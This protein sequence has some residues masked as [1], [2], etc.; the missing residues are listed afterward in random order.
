MYAYYITLSSAVLSDALESVVNVVAGLIGLYSLKLAAKPKDSNHPYGHGKIEFITSG[1]EGTLIVVSSVVILI[2]IIKGL[3]NNSPVLQIYDGIILILISAILN[4]VVGIK[5]YKIGMKNKSIVLESEGKHL[6]IDA[7]SSIIILI[8]LW[9]IH[10]TNLVIIDRIIAF[11][12]AI[13]IFYNGWKILRKSY[14]G[15]MDEIDETLLKEFI[16]EINK[17]RKIEWIDLHNL[18]VIKYGSQLHIDCHLTLP[19]FLSIKQGHEEVKSLENFIQQKFGNTIEFFVHTDSC[20]PFSCSICNN[21]LCTYRLHPFNKL[22]DWNV[23]NASN[24]KQ[25]TI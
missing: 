24:N 21:S 23:E 11:I 16:L 4:G 1:I 2:E 19:W 13:I 22:I 17:N 14:A 25:H 20:K 15:I 9:L 7:V 8:N 12:M 5:A 3:I 10:V 18:R 6:L